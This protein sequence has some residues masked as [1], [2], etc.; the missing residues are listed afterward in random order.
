M[1]INISKYFID[2]RAKRLSS[3]D[4]DPSKSNQ[5]EIGIIQDQ[6][7][8][9]GNENR[10]FKGHFIYL[11]DDDEKKI[12]C[13]VDLT[14]YDSRVNQ[15]GR[16]AEFRLYYQSNP[17]IE[18]ANSKDLLVMARRSPDE[19]TLIVAPA[20][21]NA[22]SQLMYLFGLDEKD[23]K[24]MIKNLLEHDFELNYSSE[25]IL[26]F[27]GIEIPKEDFDWLDQIVAKF[28]Y[29]FPTTR[30][31]SEFSRSISSSTD[32]LNDPDS[33]LL[34]WMEFEEMLFR[35]ME[36]HLVQQKLKDGFG[37]GGI[38]VDDFIAFSLGVQNRRKSRAG[39]A[40]ENHLECIFNV[41]HLMFS[42]GKET[43]RK[44]KPDFVFPGIEFYH[45]TNFN[46]SL[47][48]MLG[49]KTTA[50][51]RWRQVLAEAD[52]IKQKHLITLEP[53]ISTNQTSEMSSQNIQLVVPKEI[54]KT[55]K[56]G[57]QK[58]LMILDDFIK[59][60]SDRQRKL[61]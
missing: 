25:I 1:K 20:G 58:E 47:L 22:E 39:F 56:T 50:K 43:E 38:D 8:L 29:R 18:L 27:I 21:S 5:H 23:N 4:V 6:V 2:V 9:Y 15:P 33:A 53:A 60:V 51:D 37:D 52:K 45:D 24:V 57:Q 28:G 16:S 19:M 17:V 30:E 3:V 59:M 12:D 49:V 11:N 10:V 54:A 13:S 44:S 32:P 36:K 14:Y 48:T 31:F 40:F 41:H 35:T 7:K 42:R 46:V 61:S 34:K 26:E 55:Y